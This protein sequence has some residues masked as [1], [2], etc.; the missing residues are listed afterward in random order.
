MVFDLQRTLE[1]GELELEGQFMHGSN[2]TFLVKLRH[3]G[4]EFKAVYKP[5]QGEQR[6][7]DF[8]DNTLA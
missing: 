1:E 8:P 2:Y 5:S 4:R 6:L 7:W 3:A